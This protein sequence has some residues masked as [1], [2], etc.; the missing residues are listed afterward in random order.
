MNIDLAK[1]ISE[2]L[3]KHETLILPGF[4]GIVSGYKSASIDY[5]Q[6]LLYPPSRE[7][8]FNEKLTI[9]DGILER[10]VCE[11]YDLGKE[12]AEQAIGAFITRIQVS[13][14]KGEI[15]FFPKV[16]R[17]YR[18]YERK[19]QFLQ[20][21]TNYNTETYGL[22]P[23]QFYPIL[24]SK[25]G[26]INEEARIPVEEVLIVN[27]KKGVVAWVQSAMPLLIGF[28]VVGIAISIFFLRPDGALE[29][30]GPSKLPVTQRLNKKPAST[31]KAGILNIEKKT[32]I[33][34]PINKEEIVIEA[35]LDDIEE[36]IDT[37]EI[38]RAPSQKACII[39]VGAYSKKSGV[40]KTIENI[41]ELGYD[42]YKDKKKGLTRV[43]VQFAYEDANDI[44]KTL[45]QVRK[46]I[47]HKAWILKD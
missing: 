40:Q 29:Q 26:L 8:T 10:F 34:T 42:A 9:N 31:E 45:K 16:G 47:H 38:T 35:D 20:D 24:R 44:E 33:S 43:G 18:N 7:L 25:E 36:V 11:R 17:L 15:V 2:L 27:N 23:V 14:E 6:G 3:Y 13:L 19:L 30:T 21:N 1:N 28:I 22:P 41:Y 5:V 32:E 12:E 37:E 4:G 46:S 39:I